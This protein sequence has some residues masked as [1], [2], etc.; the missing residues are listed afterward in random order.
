MVKIRPYKYTDR[1]TLER[2]MVDYYTENDME[3]PSAEQMLKTISF[4]NGFPQ[5]G[6]IYIILYKDQHVGYSIVVNQWS[7][8][9]A[10]IIYFIDELYISK[11]YRKRQLE[12][13][14]IEYLLKQEEIKSIAT[15]INK[16]SRNSRRVFRFFK[17]YKDRDPL[18]VKELD[19]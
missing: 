3:P 2:M 17:F 13:N 5:C 19:E 1:Y 15:K 4:F 10:K 8:Q 7:N 6:K 9:H 18:F 12:V 11:Q 14:F 16:L